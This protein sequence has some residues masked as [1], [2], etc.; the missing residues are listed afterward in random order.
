MLFGSLLLIVVAF[1][2]PDSLLPII[3]GFMFIILLPGYAILAAIFPASKDL[4]LT[5]RMPISFALSIAIAP[6]VAVGLNYS[7]LGASLDQ[8]LLVLSAITLILTLIAL[9]MR[10]ITEN[11]Y[12]PPRLGKKRGASFGRRKGSEHKFIGIVLVIAIVASA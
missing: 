1:A 8:V 12:L 3:I 4:S 7:E 9:F 11:P 10:A 2:L 5:E 6:I